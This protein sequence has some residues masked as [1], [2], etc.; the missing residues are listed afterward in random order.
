M[1]CIKKLK[2][3]QSVGEREEPAIAVDER[4][5]NYAP[6][7]HENTVDR[8]FRVERLAERATGICQ[9]NRVRLTDTNRY[10]AVGLK[11]RGRRPRKY[12][13]IHVHFLE[14]DHGCAGGR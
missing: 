7:R 14:A 3:R 9:L 5:D 13:E 10:G 2:G 12:I 6:L 4:P 11:S 1:S 8:N